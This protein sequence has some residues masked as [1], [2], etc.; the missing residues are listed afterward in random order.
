ME[1]KFR[2]EIFIEHIANPSIQQ[3]LEEV[4]SLD[5]SPGWRDPLISYLE[6][7]LPDD[8][9]EAQRLLHLA[10]RYT[11][12]GDVLYKKS[13]PKLHFDP[14]FRCL[15]QDEAQRVM[16]GGCSLVHKIINQE[17]Y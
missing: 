9:A 3:T 13:Y 10:T 8:R 12:L 7:M 15:G 17:Y 16:H 14:Y 11:L 6:G 5:T 1:F 4:I 2:R